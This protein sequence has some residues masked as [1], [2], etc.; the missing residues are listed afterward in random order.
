VATE[1]KA[2][3]ASEKNLTEVQAITDDILKA[4]PDARDASELNAT[5]KGGLARI[6]E[7]KGRKPPPPPGPK[8]W[9]DA[10]AR[11]R[12]GDLGGAFAL[13][14]D[15]AAK[16]FAP[17]KA[18]VPKLT[19]FK[20]LYGK[21]E[22]LSAKQLN[23]LKELD[24]ELSGGQDSK[25]SRQIGT[26]LVSLFYKSASS[27][28][29][30]GE[31]GRAIEMARKVLR[32]DSQHAGA[33]SIV[34]EGRA[35]AKEIYMRGYVMEGNGDTEGALKLYEEVLAITPKDDEQHAKAQGRADKLRRGQ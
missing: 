31:W 35:Q 22:T 12:E 15:C 19:Q 9:L 3:L 27:A 13:A 1:E 21:L 33:Q 16:K 18:M 10:Q 6:N 7:L 28:K 5:A 23:D 14:N 24:D 25:M 17:C 4:Y 34:S 26:R 11:F 32:V 29:A 8:P 20:E 30:A 2:L